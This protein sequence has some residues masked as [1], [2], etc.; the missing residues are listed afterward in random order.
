MQKKSTATEIQHR[1]DDIES[2]LHPSL[3]RGQGMYVKPYYF[4]SIQCFLKQVIKA[5]IYYLSR[6]DFLLFWNNVY[7]I[8]FCLRGERA[9]RHNLGYIH[10]FLIHYWSYMRVSVIHV[11]WKSFHGPRRTIY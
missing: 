3:E 6:K 8:K 9:I 7:N 4:K 2:Q 10:L 5:P 11:C 1:N